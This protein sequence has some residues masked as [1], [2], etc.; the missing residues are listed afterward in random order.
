[1]PKLAVLAVSAAVLC[2]GVVFSAAVDVTERK[3][4]EDPITLAEA[5]DF[6]ASLRWFLLDT[7][8]NV[9]Y[10]GPVS[11]TMKDG[12]SG[13]WLVFAKEGEQWQSR[14]TL[15]HRQRQVDNGNREF[16]LSDELVLKIK[17][18]SHE[19]RIVDPLDDSKAGSSQIRTAIESFAEKYA[20]QLTTRD[21]RARQ[22]WNADR[23]D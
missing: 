4:K 14:I 21:E 11:G 1:M 16:R 20:K 9:K 8:Y 13:D 6:M 23:K 7:D 2:C 19:F 18:I 12:G 10:L 5:D 15:Q 3:D 17:W 22:F